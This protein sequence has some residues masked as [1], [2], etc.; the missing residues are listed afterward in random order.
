MDLTA[1]NPMQ[2]KAAETLEGPVLILAGA[3][4]GK[5]R[6]LTYRI[7]NLIDHGVKPWHILALTFTNK[8]AR[9]MRER[10]EK[11]VGADAQDMWLGT[12]HSICVRIL[13]RD[14]EKL[15]YQRS[16]TI[17]DDDDQLRVIKDGL[18]ALNL[19]ENRI[20]PK[21]IRNKISDAKN[22][23]LT[24]DE[25]FRESPRDYQSQ[26]LHDVFSYY[27]ERLRAA[28]A[29]DFDDLLLRTLQ[30]FV[31]HPPVLDYYRSRFQY[32][33]VD[34]YQDTNAAQYTFVR[35]LTQE[36]RNL[37]VVG[38]DDQSIYGWRG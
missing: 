34:E 4:S 18:K 37:C 21:E 25:W 20:S 30:L 19:D 33:H 26:Q 35:L 1:L 24:P 16:F 23:M 38:D 32:V 3:G 31:D 13:R 9:E 36:S 17:Y 15:G 27:E 10:V 5:T 22:K 11:L 12:F 8:A 14:I 2:R 7:A 6:T 29:L 28:N